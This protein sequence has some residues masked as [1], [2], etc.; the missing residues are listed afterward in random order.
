VRPTVEAGVPRVWSSIVSGVA[1][2]LAAVHRNTGVPGVL[3]GLSAIAAV[4]FGL[5]SA[6]R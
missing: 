2:I 1:S 3:G 6:V 4:C 5:A